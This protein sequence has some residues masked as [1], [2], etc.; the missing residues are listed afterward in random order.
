M[1]FTV[2]IASSAWIRQGL[3]SPVRRARGAPPLERVDGD[4]RRVEL[5]AAI[6]FDDVDL[7]A[8]GRLVDTDAVSEILAGHCRSLE[9]AP[10][11]DLFD[12]TPTMEVVSRE[13]FRRLKGQI[14][15]LVHVELADVEAG[16]VTR[17]DDASGS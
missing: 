4:G 14:P 13:L 9:G 2:T 16:V 3:L 15:N 6:Q 1:P 7:G 17:Y 12:S 10:W 8:R 5:R 11:T